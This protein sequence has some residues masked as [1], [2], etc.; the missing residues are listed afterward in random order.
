MTD[1]YGKRGPWHSGD[2]IPPEDGVWERKYGSGIIF[3][4]GFFNGSWGWHNTNILTAST[5]KYPTQAQ[6][7]PWRGLANKP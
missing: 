3:F 5:D 4:C 2:E 7:L 6:K 1:K